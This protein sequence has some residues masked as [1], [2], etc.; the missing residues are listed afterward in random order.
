MEAHS[1]NRLALDWAEMRAIGTR[2]ASGAQTPA[3]TYVTIRF[4]LRKAGG[5][6]SGF[7]TPEQTAAWEQ[8][9]VADNPPPR[10]RLLLERLGYVAISTVVVIDP[11]AASDYATTAQQLIQE[12]D[13]Q[14]PC[15]W[16]LDLRQNGGGNMYPM[17]AG[18]GPVLGEG[19]AGQFIDPEDQTTTWAYRDGQLFIGTQE[20]VG[21]RGAAYTL[22]AENP[23][24]AVL[25]GRN[26]ASSG[27]AVAISFIGRPNTRSFGRATAGYTTSN[28]PFPLSDG[29]VLN[30]TTAT[31]ADR[32]GR[33]YDHRL[34]PD[35]VAGDQPANVIGEERVPRAAVDWLMAQPACG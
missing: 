13:A 16:I 5:L 19:V 3:D 1:I 33:I 17:L 31:M 2:V 27:E 18:L 29:A 23:P 15:G 20:V 32:T 24:V 30:L 34:N 28:A 21:V 8:M 25:I 12:V 7:F 4:L 26:T 6:H 35:E 11:A 22:Q 14:A 10:A 9:T